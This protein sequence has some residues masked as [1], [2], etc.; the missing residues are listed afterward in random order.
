MCI[1]FDQFHG[2]NIQLREGLS[3]DIESIGNKI[4]FRTDQLSLANRVGIGRG[5]TNGVIRINEGAVTQRTDQLLEGRGSSLSRVLGS[6]VGIDGIDLVL[7]MLGKHTQI[8]Q[9]SLGTFNIT[10][11]QSLTN[12][13]GMLQSR[14]LTIDTR[15][16]SLD[17]TGYDVS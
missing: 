12:T 13:L 15:G 1:Q 14:Q 4:G 8:F 10:L 6:H 7:H 2:L 9:T 5:N 3:Q 17:S 11:N 16:S